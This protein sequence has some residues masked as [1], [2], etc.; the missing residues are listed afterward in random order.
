[1]QI[2]IMTAHKKIHTIS[3]IELEDLTLIGLKRNKVEIVTV[4]MMRSGGSITLDSLLTRRIQNKD[5]KRGP[6]RRKNVYGERRDCMRP[7]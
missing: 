7:S 5:A 6:I 4:L 2:S 1:M 3:V